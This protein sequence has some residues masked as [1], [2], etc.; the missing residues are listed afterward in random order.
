MP[1][2]IFLVLGIIQ[3]GLIAQAR[4][5]SKYAAYRAVRVGAMNNADVDKMENAAI[6]YL[7]PVISVKSSGGAK[8][9][10]TILPTRNASELSAKYARALAGNNL[11]GNLK[12]VKV[13]VCGPLEQELRGTGTDPLPNVTHNALHG[14]GSENEVDF[15][16]P[17]I[18][19]DNDSPVSDAPTMTGTLRRHIRT[20]LRIQVQFHY[21]MPI[22]FANWVIAHAYIGVKV[23]GVLRLG[24]RE[25]TFKNKFMAEYQAMQQGIF[26]VPINS[27]YSFRMQS[28]LFLTRNRLPTTNLCEHYR[29]SE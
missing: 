8:A 26:V 7:L 3:L 17:L 15:D 13:V 23:P 4:A 5:L 14:S 6:F 11:T 19:T 28:N 10:D 25:P 2:M 16:D 12:M 9:I 27:N 18:A 29:T 20:K 22:P 24:T 1:L 21:R